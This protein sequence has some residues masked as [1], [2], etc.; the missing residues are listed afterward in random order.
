[1]LFEFSG[2]KKAY[3]YL[4]PLQKRLKIEFGFD[5]SRSLQLRLQQNAY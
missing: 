3:I 1:M 4:K 2:I 5:A